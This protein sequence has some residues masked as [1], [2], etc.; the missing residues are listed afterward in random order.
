MPGLLGGKSHNVRQY[1]V[2]HLKICIESL[3]LTTV[4]VRTHR[5]RGK[6][7][8][9]KVLSTESKKRYND[10]LKSGPQL[11]IG[12]RLTAGAFKCLDTRIDEAA[13]MLR[14]RR[15]RMHLRILHRL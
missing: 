8:S 11:H 7:T 3:V 2:N 9:D 6:L 5:H 10:T 4:D 12:S 1:F 15:G 13:D 14:S